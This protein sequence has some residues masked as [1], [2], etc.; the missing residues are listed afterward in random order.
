LKT[1]SLLQ[2]LL[3]MKNR[4][5]QQLS[6]VLEIC[7]QR[8]VQ[9]R[10][11]NLITVLLLTTTL[12]LPALFWTVTANLSKLSH[13]SYNSA[14]ISMYLSTEIKAS[15]IE[16]LLNKVRAL[17]SVATVQYIS[18]EEGLKSLSQ[19]SD[20]S[21]LISALPK[22][23]LPP[24]ITLALKSSDHLS[25]EAKALQTQLSTFQH[26]ETVQ[27]DSVWLQRLQIILTT[28]KE[29]SLLL[30]I[31]LALGVVLI[32]SNSIQLTLERHRHEIAIFQLVGAN[33]IFI[34]APFLIAGMFIGLA[35]GAFTW[36]IISL[37]TTW[38]SH[39]L[40]TL[41]SLY[42]S[43]FQL[44]HFGFI[45]GFILLFASSLLGTLGATIASRDYG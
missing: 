22:N 2:E 26:V 20:F 29:L 33:S 8:M 25:E 13:R 21:G 41:V 27:L 7:V 32:V 31:L 43:N 38:L 16:A 44:T 23:P 6:N 35:A 5:L 36:L 45:Q 17:P 3:I 4:R 34:R 9:Y 39:N 37:I 30:G 14:E 12:C 18:P 10:G 15:E 40:N 19:Q 1:R 28:L 11:A 24:V 42:Q